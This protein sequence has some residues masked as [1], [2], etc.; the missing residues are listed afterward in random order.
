[1]VNV[2]KECDEIEKVMSGWLLSLSKEA[3]KPPV[4]QALEAAIRDVAQPALQCAVLTSLIMIGQQL[5]K[6]SSAISSQLVPPMLA[7]A[8][9]PAV[10]QFQPA[11]GLS[12][13]ANFNVVDLAFT[14]LSFMNERGPAGALLVEVRQHFKDHPEQL[15]LLARYSLENGTLITPVVPPLS[16]HDYQRYESA[17]RRWIPLRDRYKKA[18]PVAERDIDACL[19]IH[20]TLLDC[21]RE[22]RYPTATLLL[23]LLAI[24]V[25]A[26]TP[27]QQAWQTH[28]LAQ[29]DTGHYLNY[30]QIALFWTMLFPEKQEMQILTN[31]ILMHY[32]GTEITVRRN[33]ECFISSLSMNLVDL[34]YLGY[35]GYLVDLKYLVEN[36]L[37]REVA[38]QARKSILSSDLV[39]AVNMLKILL[40]RIIQIKDS[41]ATDSN[42]KKEVQ[43]IIASAKDGHAM[44]GDDEVKEAA[45]DILRY[46]PVRSA[47][48]IRDVIQLAESATDGDLRQAYASSLRR[49]RPGKD[50]ADAWKELEVGRKSHVDE[51][52]EAAE[53]VFEQAKRN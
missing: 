29:L 9:L 50:D 1:M 36:L 2:F 17:I 49:A 48:E 13:S 37:T 24:G 16:D 30:Q 21:A 8:G 14:A 43:D 35:L 5:T 4:L 44:Q 31:H 20:N 7:L 41:G 38:E 11:S 27:W 12:V 10:G 15:E 34:K 19:E 3:Y 28:L 51:V 45:L 26:S 46:L 39:R 23:D 53:S 6:G 32:S 42:T 47:D 18:H 33:A 52:R 25:N 40:G 22:A